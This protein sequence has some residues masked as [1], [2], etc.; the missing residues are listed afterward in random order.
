[1]TAPLRVLF[2]EDNEDDLQLTLRELR[3]GS[4]EVTWERVDTRPG[5]VGALAERAWDLVICDH[6]MP[7]FSSREALEVM[8]EQGPDIPF[9]VVSG[10]AP[11]EIVTEAMRMGAHDFISKSSLLRLVPAVQRELREASIRKER[12]QIA[13]RL[14]E[15]EGRYGTLFN[16]NPAPMLLVDGLT[17]L[18]VDANPAAAAFFGYTLENLKQSNVQAFSRQARKGAWKSVQR[19]REQRGYLFSDSILRS[20]GSTRDIDVYAVRIVQ[21]GRTLLLATLFDQ[22]E[23]MAAEAALKESE[24]RFRNLADSAPVLIWTAGADGKRDYFNQPWLAFT[25]RD[26]GQESGH[27]WIEG[28]HG[29]DRERFLAVYR[30]AF[31][32]RRAFQAEYRLRRADHTFRWILER[33]VPRLN[34]G[35]D[36][37]GFVGSSLDITDRKQ[38]EESRVKM[39]AAVEQV[40]D[41]IAI[42][43]PS[44][45]IEYVNRAFV[46]L[47]SFPLEQV[48]EWALH[49]VLEHA[50]IRE[51]LRKAGL[52]ESWEGRVSIQVDNKRARELDITC[53]P[54]RDAKGA[55]TNLVAVLRDITQEAELERQL[56]QTHKMDALGAL[57]AGIAHDFNNVLT[58]ILTATQLIK[59][60]L[61]A[62]SPI[63]SKVDA[64]HQAGLVAAG[65]TKQI[66]SFSHKPEDKRLALDFSSVVK[67]S[68]Q[69]L[70]SSQPPH[71]EIESSI[72]SGIW[73]EGDP[74]QL[75]QVVLNLSLNAFHAMKPKGGTLRLALAETSATAEMLALGLQSGRYAVLTV[76]DSGCGMD[77][78]TLERIFDPFFTTKPAGEGT[79][80]GLSMVH[81]T[82][83][84]AGGRIKVHS[85]PGEG[86]TFQIFWPCV[87]GHEIPATRTR[88]DEVKG[89]ET[90]L[91][92]DDEELVAALAKLSLQELGYTVYVRTNP[93]EALE[94]FK[95]HPGQYDLVFTDMVMPEM[96]GAELAAS[97]HEL[98]PE[99]PVLLVSGLPTAR[100]LATGHRAGFQDVI[101]KPFT[102]YDLASAARKALKGTERREPRIVESPAPRGVSA[103][104][105]GRVQRIL[106]AEDSSTTRSMIRGWL[107]KAGYSVRAVQ[108]GQEAWDLFTDKNRPRFDLVLTDVVMPRLDGLE[109]TQLV[110]RMD[111]VVPIAILTSNEDKE[112]VKSALHL[113]ANEFLNKPFEAPELLGCVERL[114]VEHEARLEERRSVETAQAVK[115]AQRTMV[116]VPEKDLPLFSLYEPLTHAGG[117]VFRC[118]KCADGSILFVLADVA[119]H[120]VY[121]SY[122]VAA[123]LAML[124][125]FISECNTLLALSPADADRS[126]KSCALC[127]QIAC[128]P[129]NHLAL[130]LN[131]GIQSGPFS[132]IP[133]CALIGLWDPAGGSL[134]LLNAGIPHGLLLRK[135]ED[136][137]SFIELNGTPLGVFLEPIVEDVR[138]HLAPGDRLLF[139]TDGFFD[140]L[141]P[142][143]K[144]FQDEVPECWNNLRESPI[145]WALSVV[146]EK[147]K[148]HGKGLITDDLLVVGFEQAP[149]TRSV[150]ELRLQLPSTTHA[151]DMACNRLGEFLRGPSLETRIGA[152]KRFD[153]LV[154]VREALTNAVFHGNASRSEAYVILQCR[155]DLAR[156]EVAITISDEGDGFDLATQAPPDDPLSERGRG[157]QIMRAFSSGIRMS[158]N[159]LTMTFHLEEVL[160]DHGQGSADREED[161]RGAE[162]DAQN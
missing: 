46:R 117:D 138:L 9:F 98:R 102:P 92:V 139:A 155:Y 33:G 130:K 113:G 84:K 103:L 151:I 20:D 120:S 1:M 106:L 5:M 39:G 127:G 104:Q 77:P 23:R 66:L 108:D 61:A 112:T 122:A 143:R 14:A 101:L 12:R 54:V 62:D 128:A 69:I 114:L 27:G 89:S 64:I 79:G 26:L 16:E 147:A 45:V 34:P 153:M 118:L 58:T 44:G 78:L 160:H 83:T 74:A 48:H 3:K 119:G 15:S 37:A 6:V 144:P 36:L 150:D 53:S 159:E 71:T 8:Q 157:L 31:Q 125:T 19:T 50:D 29:E 135:G 30:N 161:R 140:V 115:L 136:R 65:L 116:A 105:P 90:L 126:L 76:R 25:G 100:T 156:G 133:V 81:A 56:R 17:L 107:E 13:S 47:T 40:A 22:T 70:R 87:T 134:C 21:G 42:M 82:V 73:V 142:Q 95:G 63:H 11:E 38:A 124:S 35:G 51:A 145:D 32:A 123:F 57:A 131:Q 7:A 109:L 148:E 141:S 55:V 24:V 162:V 80:L 60:G 99:L 85:R 2:I 149:I 129:L 59:E 52:G 111:P 41:A 110:R 10:H 75:H 132:E 94:D 154:A 96:S 68:L 43:D 67:S 137:P 93:M 86:T 97:L 28:V 18:V 88:L 72:S 49:D 91:F 152:S 146:C 121:S 4:F 158:G